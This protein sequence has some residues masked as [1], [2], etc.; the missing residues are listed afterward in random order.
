[1]SCDANSL[2][3]TAMVYIQ[4][5]P[6]ISSALGYQNPSVNTILEWVDKGMHFI[7][8]CDLYLDEN[9]KFVPIPNKTY[10]EGKTLYS[11]GWVQNMVWCDTDI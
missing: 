7:I 4:S 6:D 1:V 3:A 5:F 9:L 10:A 8:H 2:Y 11:V